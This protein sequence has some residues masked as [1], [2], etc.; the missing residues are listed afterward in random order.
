MER[1]WLHNHNHHV[2]ERERGYHPDW[3]WSLHPRPG[4][5]VEV[6]KTVDVNRSEGA[7]CLAKVYPR[8]GMDCRIRQTRSKRI[9]KSKGKLVSDGRKERQAWLLL[10]EYNR[11]AKRKIRDETDNRTRSNA[12]TSHARHRGQQHTTIMARLRVMPESWSGE[13]DWITTRTLRNSLDVKRAR[14][15]AT[16][17]RCPARG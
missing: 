4:V 13:K 6:V 15:D 8:T 2:E 17:L 10:Y 12:Q 14:A 7:S 1:R 9:R 11:R 3:G 5:V 16:T